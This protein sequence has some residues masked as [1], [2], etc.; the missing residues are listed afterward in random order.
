MGSATAVYSAAYDPWGNQ[1]TRTTGG[2]TGTL[3]YDQSNRLT[4]WNAG[5][6]SQEFYLY[7]ATGNRILKRSITGTGTTLSV[8]SFGLEENDYSGTGVLSTQTHY[9]NLASHLIGSFDGTNTTYYMTDA[10]DSVLTAFSQ[11]AIQGEQVYGPFGA[12]SYQSGT[13]NTAKGYTGQVHDGVSGLDYYV[14][15]YYDPV[16][17]MFLSVDTVQGNQ[18]GMNPYQYVGSNPETHNDPSGH[19][20]PWCTALAGALIGAVVGSVVSIVQQSG[21]GK[22]INWG[23][24]AGAAAWGAAAGAAIGIA[25]PLALDALAAGSVAA[26]AA[27]VGASVLSVGVTTVAEA[28]LAAFTVASSVAVVAASVASNASNI[29]ASTTSGTCSF[30]PDTLVTTKDGK[31]PIG[32]LHTGDSVLAYN[33]NTHKMELQPILHVWVHADNDL[34]NVTITPVPAQK[35]GKASQQKELLHTTSEHP[36]LTKEKGFLPAGQLKPGM[37]VL[38]A[39]GSIGVVTDWKRV[40]GTSVMYNLTVQQDHTFVVGVDQWVVHNVCVETPQQIAS[41]LRTQV[42]ANRGNTSL[43]IKKANGR[44]TNSISELYESNGKRI[45]TGISDA[46]KEDPIF[47]DV[48]CSE[49]NCLINGRTL[50]QKGET[51]DLYTA[52]NKG[53][54]ACDAC[55]EDLQIAADKA[56]ITIRDFSVGLDGTIA[57]PVVYS[58]STLIDPELDG[59]E[60]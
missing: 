21:S 31:K 45:A 33:P 28:G 18:Q 4:E 40:P 9:Y 10:L 42:T 41:R 57:E 38:R 55:I 34:I 36:F 59:E 48:Q 22:P 56:G 24:V 53:Y 47:G 3:S 23:N 14:A 15:R 1:T 25:G 5:S 2:V 54:P 27:T 16:M 39:D 12:S 49:G 58:P 7:D 52:Q 51:Y 37:H 8:Y 60:P 32:T 43:A 19:C 13:I 17:G 29:V 44:P 11:S 46:S 30:T 35:G 6:T 20:W 50:L 26:A